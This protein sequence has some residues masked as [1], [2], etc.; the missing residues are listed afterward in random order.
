M[1]RAAANMLVVDDEPAIARSLSLLF[2]RRGHRVAVAQGGNAAL[3]LM[4]QTHFECV[5]L[6]YRLPDIRGDA[7][8]AYMVARQPHLSRRVIFLTGDIVPDVRDVLDRTG[9]RVVTKP[10]ELAELVALVDEVLATSDQQARDER[11][12]EYDERAG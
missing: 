8:Y 7:L 3:D 9:C 10:F 2:T 12:P 1:V 5:V 6:D 4:A 11:D